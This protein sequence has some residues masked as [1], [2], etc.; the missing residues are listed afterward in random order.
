MNKRTYSFREAQTSTASQNE[1][2]RISAEGK[3][4]F[5]ARN[6]KKVNIWDELKPR[7]DNYNNNNNNNNNC[8]S[9]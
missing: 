6:K 1:I 8:I 5:P 4:S 2:S 9:Q 7:K 3:C